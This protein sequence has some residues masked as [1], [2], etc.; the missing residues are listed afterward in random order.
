[1][2]ARDKG[3]LVKNSLQELSKAYYIYDGNGRATSVYVADRDAADGSVCLLTVFTYDGASARV[4]KFKESEDVWS[5]AY[6]I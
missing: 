1:M 3:T 6:D 4:E 2:S 5:A